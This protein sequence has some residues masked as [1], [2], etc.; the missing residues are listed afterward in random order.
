ME[1]ANLTEWDKHKE[2][3]INHVKNS[4]DSPTEEQNR[5]YDLLVGA[6]IVEGDR[7]QGHNEYLEGLIAG[8]IKMITRQGKKLEAIRRLVKKGVTDAK[9]DNAYGWNYLDYEKM[10]E[11]LGE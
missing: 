9:R 4:D 6:L 1:A 8:D 7:L 5:I 3:L 10:L 11:V 2:R